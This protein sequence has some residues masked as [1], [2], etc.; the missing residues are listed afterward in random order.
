[1]V[2]WVRIAVEAVFACLPSIAAEFFLPIDD[3]NPHARGQRHFWALILLF[4]SLVIGVPF[5]VSLETRD[6]VK[7]IS[8][9]WVPGRFEKLDD[10]YDHFFARTAGP[11]L[12]AWGN[13]TLG[14][15]QS[16]WEQGWMP[17]RKEQER[18]E[19]R[20]VFTLAR[21]FIVATNVGSTNTFF[22]D[23]NDKYVEAN[24]AANTQNH[25]PVVRFY[26]Y[27]TNPNYRLVKADGKTPVKDKDDFFGEVTRLH[28][29]LGSFYSAVIDMDRPNHPDDVRDLLLMDDIFGSEMLV[30]KVNWTGTRA[31]ATER[32]DNLARM[33][34]Y[35]NS[36][37]NAVDHRYV[38]QMDSKST[39][40]AYGQRYTS[41][42]KRPETAAADLIACIMMDT[43]KLPDWCPAGSSSDATVADLR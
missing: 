34:S 12:S 29:L 5:E 42:S 24:K 28:K 18:E 27:S 13:D 33:R 19:V 32:R 25:I 4:F 37:Y 26:L 16:S 30:D 39:I 8:T 6:A 20:P 21:R 10:L 2:P 35:V 3:T 7:E 36:L 11:I 1:M 31:Q 38:V 9:Q 23:D 15:L 22:D 17:L 41:L 43:T 14:Y 40:T